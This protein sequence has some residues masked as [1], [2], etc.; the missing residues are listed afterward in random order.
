[1]LKGSCLCKAVTYTLDEELS[2]LVF[3]TVHS[4]GKQLRLPIQLMLKLAVKI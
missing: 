1:M 3:S 2:E 4:V